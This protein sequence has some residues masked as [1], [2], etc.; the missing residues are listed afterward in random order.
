MTY[1]WQYANTS[2]SY[3]SAYT[4]IPGA[5]KATYTVDAVY[6]GKY[7]RVNVTSENTVFSTQKKSSYGTQSVAPLGPVTLKGQYS[8]RASNL[9]IRTLR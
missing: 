9:P 2:S 8:W 3:D 4:D 1:Q 5:T 6:A 7:L